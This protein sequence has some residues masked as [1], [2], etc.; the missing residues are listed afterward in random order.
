M[1]HVGGYLV[2]QFLVTYWV[3]LRICANLLQRDSAALS[4]PVLVANA[5]TYALLA[6]VTAF[7]VLV[8]H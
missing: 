4:K 2:A 8:A 5:A 3:E 6:L 7:G 1:V